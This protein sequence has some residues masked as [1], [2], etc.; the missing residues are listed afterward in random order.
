ME[1][2]FWKLTKF[3]KFGCKALF[4]LPDTSATFD[5]TVLSKNLLQL[6]NFS[7]TTLMNI[8]RYQH[9][10]PKIVCPIFCIT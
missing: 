8:K 10:N 3:L 2:L 9:L 6:N 7:E 5:V 1:L 4:Y